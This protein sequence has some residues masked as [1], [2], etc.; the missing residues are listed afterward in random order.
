[1]DDWIAR[2]VVGEVGRDPTP[3]E[4]ATVVA[5]LDTFVAPE[6]EGGTSL[7]KLSGSS[8]QSATAVVA[9]M[10]RKLNRRAY[11]QFILGLAILS[12]SYGILVVSGGTMF[13]PFALLSLERRTRLL[14]LFSTS[15]VP[16]LIVLYRV[17][18]IMSMTH[19]YMNPPTSIWAEIGYPGP[20]LVRSAIPKR[21]PPQYEFLGEDALRGAH[22]DVII[23]GSGAGGSVCASVLAQAGKSVL[24]VE[25]GKYYQSDQ[26]ALIEQDAMEKMFE[27]EGLLA[28]ENGALLLF[29]G[30]T[31]GGGTAVN[32]SASLRPPNWLREEWAKKHDLPSFLSVEFQDAVDA[33]CNRMGVSDTFTVHNVSNMKML[34]ACQRLGFHHQ[35]IPQNT[36]LKEHRCGFCGLGCP[37]GVKQSGP[38]SWLCDARDA[39]AKFVQ[40]CMVSRV[41]IE[42]GTAVGI[43]CSIRNGPPIVVRS[44]IVVCSAGSLHSPALLLRSGLSNRHIGKHFGVH[45]VAVAVGLF[46]EEIRTW[47]GSIMTALSNVAGNQDGQH[48]GAKLEIPMMHPGLFATLLQWSSSAQ[49]KRDFARFK[50]AL[51]VISLVRDRDRDASVSV[52]EEGQPQIDFNV[53]PFDGESV[54]DGLIHAVKVLVAAGANE[55]RTSQGSVGA[56]FPRSREINDPD[57]ERFIANV[58]RHGVHN[59]DTDLFSAHQMGTCRMGA[60]PDDGV[61]SPHGEVWECTNLFVAD[62]SVFPTSSGVNPMI[63][64]YAISYMT[65]KYIASDR[66]WGRRQ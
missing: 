65:A 63:T 10:R 19:V 64:N 40:E 5:V 6:H 48:Y 29:A 18:K 31:F 14:N 34:D 58:S 1:M 4:L 28:S 55:V 8:V 60:S 36:G 9:S 25:K 37:S 50:H 39:G 33:V 62:A 59:L 38:E 54:T 52:D 15:P 23:V 17:L 20:D 57:V 53:S 41:V 30:S 61:V 2:Y 13:S 56:L 7:L 22:F 27:R 43:E 49:H 16:N 32:W 11:R 45:P 12:N 44:A 42:N 26:H 51:P 24:V 46:D 35:S 3:G 21:T 66:L 47:D